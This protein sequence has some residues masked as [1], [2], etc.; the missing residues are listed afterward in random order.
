MPRVVKIN[1]KDPNVNE[2]TLNLIE[3]LSDRGM[4]VELVIESTKVPVQN[5]LPH[6]QSLPINVL[7]NQPKVEKKKPSKTLDENIQD[8]DV[9]GM[10]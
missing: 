2:E 6:T 10:L 4:T 7:S 5:T 9:F 3:Q 1:L 8:D